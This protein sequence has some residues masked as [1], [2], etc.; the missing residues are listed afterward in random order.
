MQ[1]HWMAPILFAAALG[2][3]GCQS[4]GSTA[5]A[6]VPGTPAPKDTAVFEPA[7]DVR[8]DRGSKTCEWR[9]GPSVGLTRL[10][11]GDGAANALEPRMAASG[12]KYDPIFKPST[13]VSCDTLVITCYGEG[14]A[15]EDLTRSY[16]GP[17]A[18]D[19]LNARRRGSIQRY[20]EYITCDRVSNICYD[21]LGAGVGITRLYIGEAESDQLLKRLRANL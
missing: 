14:G 7:K 15:S 17:K 10:Y 21:R 12:Y 8:C 9:D 20:G 18:A 1:R 6:P 3:A 19:K 2:A 13:R 4:G 11:F 5:A 16:F